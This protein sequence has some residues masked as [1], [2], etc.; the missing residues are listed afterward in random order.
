VRQSGSS[1]GVEFDP[2]S[3]TLLASGE[4]SLPIKG[5]KTPCPSHRG[6]EGPYRF[7]NTRMACAALGAPA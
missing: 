2:H 6:R 1:T 3:L 5:G 4:L 7:R